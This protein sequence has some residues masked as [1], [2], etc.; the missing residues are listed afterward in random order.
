MPS[1]EPDSSTMEIEDL[2][3]LNDEHSGACGGAMMNALAHTPP[4]SG[5]TPHQFEMPQQGLQDLQNQ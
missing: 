5:T 3:N 2:D 1:G 4:R